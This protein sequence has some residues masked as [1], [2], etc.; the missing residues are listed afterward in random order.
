MVSSRVAVRIVRRR[1]TRGVDSQ[2]FRT[3]AGIAARIANTSDPRT[4]DFPTSKAINMPRVLIVDDDPGVRRVLAPALL[5]LGIEVI[6]EAEDGFDAIEM[7][8][9]CLPDVVLMDLQMPGMNGLEATREI[10]ERHPFVEVVFVTVYDE[11]HPT[12]SAEEAGAY[13]YL[14]KDSSPELMRDIIQR[15]A[16]HKSEQEIRSRREA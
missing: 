1:C 12:R 16:T 2:P 14:L 7:V 10:K 9:R 5:R 3:V 4:V 11:E 6:G 13:A 15:A 8:D